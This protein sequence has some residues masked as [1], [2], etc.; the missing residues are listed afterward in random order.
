MQ[1]FWNQIQ[2]Q[3][4]VY[5]PRIL[6]AIVV[7]VLFWFLSWM[8]LRVIQRVGTGMKAN[9]VIVDLISQIVKF[10][11]LGIGLVC[12]LAT[13]GI[14]VTAVIASFG[15]AGFAIGFALKDVLSN[16]MS[17]LMLLYY[18]PFWL[19]DRIKVSGHEGVITD[20]D[21]RYTTLYTDEKRILIP[22]S[23]LFTNTVEI[24]ATAPHPEDE[25]KVIQS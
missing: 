2:T 14:D 23:N 5:A 24:L 8:I 19:N 17:G 22:N 25:S 7:L 20:I 15:I 9:Q 21:L 1:E 16:V 4:Q 18:K 6:W 12:A 11:V 10:L 13:L 3:V